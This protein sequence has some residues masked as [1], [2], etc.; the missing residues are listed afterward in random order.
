ML[1]IANFS[2]LGPS[3]TFPFSV[4]GQVVV[5]NGGVVGWRRGQLCHSSSSY[6]GQRHLAATQVVLLSAQLLMASSAIEPQKTIKSV[7]RLWPSLSSLTLLLTRSNKYV[8]AHYFKQWGPKKL[9]HCPPWE[10]TKAREHSS[11]DFHHSFWIKRWS[12]ASDRVAVDLRGTF[13]WKTL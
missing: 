9:R 2:G 13:I 1:K 8:I 7:W 12:R 5:V 11:K 4:F 6:Y 3:A 10:T